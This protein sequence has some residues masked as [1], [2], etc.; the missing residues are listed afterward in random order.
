VVLS[1]VD[2]GMTLLARIASVA[3][4]AAVM[5]SLATLTW[6]TVA[7]AKCVTGTAIDYND[8]DAVLYTVR[9]RAMEGGREGLNGYRPDQIAGSSLWA[10]WAPWGDTGEY[11]QFSLPGQVGTY[12]ISTK[13]KDVVKLLRND[14][15]YE[16]SPPF[17]NQIDGTH[18]VLTVRR[19]SVVTRVIISNGDATFADPATRKVFADV[20][21]LIERAKKDRMSD[22]PILFEQKLLFDQ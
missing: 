12:W 11:A 20:L 19:C 15:F 14:R 18:S 4:S 7:L 1:Y 8:I 10:F 13:L 21:Q 9:Y 3:R 17:D 6:P 22:T 2:I 16:L 5:A